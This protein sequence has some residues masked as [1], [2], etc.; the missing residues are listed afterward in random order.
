MS[1]IL[2][3]AIYPINLHKDILRHILSQ[4]IKLI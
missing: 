2:R 1:H 3:L 4:I